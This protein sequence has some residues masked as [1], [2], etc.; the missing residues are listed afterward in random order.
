MA[1]FA[2]SNTVKGDVTKNI[3]E[4]TCEPTTDIGNILFE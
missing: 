4:K 3:S 2:K 1:F